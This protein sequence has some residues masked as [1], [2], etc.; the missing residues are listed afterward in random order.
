MLGGEPGAVEHARPVLSA[1]CATLTHLG[2]AGAGQAG[3]L[4]NQIAIAGT[5]AGLLAAAG[6]ASLQGLDLARCFDAL[7]AGS[8]HSVQMD[9]HRAALTRAP[10]D[11]VP[12]DWLRRDLALAL[13]HLPADETATSD[14]SQALLDRLFALYQVFDGTPSSPLL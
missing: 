4:A 13:A 1:Y 2:P 11:I 12:F 8:A 6:F 14:T 9:Q 3:K 7:A 5:N 10:A